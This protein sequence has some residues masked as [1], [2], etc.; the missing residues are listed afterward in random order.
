MRFFFDSQS[1][2]ESIID[3]ESSDDNVVDHIS[4]NSFGDDIVTFK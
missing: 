4:A 2:N 1:L 3:S